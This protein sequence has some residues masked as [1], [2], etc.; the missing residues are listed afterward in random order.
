MWLCN[1]SLSLNKEV[2]GSSLYVWTTLINLGNVDHVCRKYGDTFVCA[3]GKIYLMS[4]ATCV[5]F[6]PSL[7]I[8]QKFKGCEPPTHHIHIQSIHNNLK[9]W[10]VVLTHQL[11]FSPIFEYSTL[12]IMRNGCDRQSEV[13]CIVMSLFMLLVQRRHM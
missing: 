9:R 4:G 6:E 12:G 5:S 1:T 8:A 11:L 13:P 7:Y 3:A 2:A 10:L